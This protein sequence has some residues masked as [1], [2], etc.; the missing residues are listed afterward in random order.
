MAVTVNRQSWPRQDDREVGTWTYKLLA[1]PLTLRAFPGLPSDTALKGVSQGNK[2]LNPQPLSYHSQSEPRSSTH[3]HLR[4]PRAVLKIQACSPR[5]ASKDT[6]PHCYHSAPRKTGRQHIQDL[7]LCS[8]WE[9][10]SHLLEKV[11][12][13]ARLPGQGLIPHLGNLGP[14]RAQN[15]PNVT[16][17][18]SAI[19]R[20]WC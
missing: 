14:E 3:S 10:S 5:K 16:Q 13:K 6:Q 18:V 7:G 8:L 2:V 20:S 15:Q 12:R 17:E 19:L 11:S 1:D 4:T 9:L